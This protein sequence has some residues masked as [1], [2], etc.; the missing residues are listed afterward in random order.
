MFSA[1]LL[2]MMIHSLPPP[3][4][5][6]FQGSP[7]DLPS[8][9]APQIIP[10]PADI[11]KRLER[12]INA[13]TEGWA[14]IPIVARANPGHLPKLVSAL[15]PDTPHDGPRGFLWGRIPLNILIAHYLTNGTM[16]IGWEHL[17]LGTP[18]RAAG[19]STLTASGQI[20]RPSS[21][22]HRSRDPLRSARPS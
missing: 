19:P 9:E 5:G 3:A 7:D 1:S 14:L 2:S 16:E 11:A 18:V 6:A 15:S 12:A 13:Q 4:R 20:A 22:A 17:D 10:K 21:P 8:G